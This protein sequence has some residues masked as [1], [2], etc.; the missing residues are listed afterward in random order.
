MWI[1]AHQQAALDEAARQREQERAAKRAE[2]REARRRRVLM[3]LEH[4]NRR[5]ARFGERPLDPDAAGWSDDDV[6][7]EARRVGWLG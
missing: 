3:A 7:A 5:R 2:E 6:L 4:I 1:P